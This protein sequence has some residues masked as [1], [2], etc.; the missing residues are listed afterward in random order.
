MQFY[1][2]L[3]DNLIAS[4]EKPFLYIEKGNQQ[5][6]IG[7]LHKRKQESIRRSLILV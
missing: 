6:K 5:I 3:Y 4:R 7:G 2:M 1:G